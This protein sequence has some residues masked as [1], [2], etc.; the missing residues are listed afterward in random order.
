VYAVRYVGGRWQE[1]LALIQRFQ[2]FVVP[3]L[4]VLLAVGV[5]LF[6]RRGSSDS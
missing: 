4:L 2:T 5:W 6:I 1:I 3:A